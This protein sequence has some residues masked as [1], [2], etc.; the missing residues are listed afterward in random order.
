M[1]LNEHLSRM[2]R[3]MI[4]SDYNTNAENYNTL[5]KALAN[6]AELRITFAQTNDGIRGDVFSEYPMD[7][8]YDYELL[9]SIHGKNKNEVNSIYNNMIEKAK[10]DD[11][12][13]SDDENDVQIPF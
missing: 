1:K 11:M 8:G 12:D 4:E 9:F 3:L 7:S 2:K 13:F 5:R 6:K 10:T